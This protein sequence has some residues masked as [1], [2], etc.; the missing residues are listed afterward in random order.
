M[1]EWSKQVLE[2]IKR[3]TDIQRKMW[4]RWWQALP[5]LRRDEPADAWRE[6]YTENLQTWEGLVK[7]GLATQA[8][9]A[10]NWVTK[11]TTAKGMSVQDVPKEVSEWA[12]RVKEMTEDWTRAQTRLW[13]GWFEMLKNID[14]SKPVETAAQEIK[15]V[16]KVLEEVAEKSVEI[17][18]L[19]ARA[20]DIGAA[21]APPQDKDDLKEISGIGATLER[22]LNEHGIFTYRQIAEWNDEDIKRIER[23]IIRFSGRVVREKWVEQAKRKCTLK[24]SEQA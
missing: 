24:D 13:E 16:V 10:R 4:D 22:R 18:P 23:D 21:S 3:L 15:Q 14:P 19:S 20:A 2:I 5:A 8:E 7:N 9:W 12:E 6:S 1:S 11:L 17:P